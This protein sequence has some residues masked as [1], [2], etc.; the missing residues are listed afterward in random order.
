MAVEVEGGG[1]VEEFLGVLGRKLHVI[2]GPFFL[3]LTLGVCFSVIVP[4]KFVTE[5]RVMVR[6]TIADRS[7][8]SST[9]DEA[10]LASH[11]I[12]AR[13][14]VEKVLDELGWP[15]YENLSENLKL[16]FAARV[17][18]NIK[19]AVPPMPKGSTSQIVQIGYMD[20]DPDH[21]FAFLE[22]LTMVWRYEVLDQGR[23]AVNHSWRLLSDERAKLRNKRDELT[24]KMTERRQEF[25]IPVNGQSGGESSL[26]SPIFSQLDTVTSNIEEAKILRIDLEAKVS[27]HREQYDKM[28][29]TVRVI[30]VEEEAVDKV[31]DVERVRSK[32]FD[33]RRL[34]EEKGYKPANSK[35][36]AI[37]VQI[38][39]YEDEIRYLEGLDRGT[40]ERPVF[41]ENEER[42]KLAGQLEEFENE[43]E[44]TVGLIEALTSKR[45]ELMARSNELQEVYSELATW[46]AERDSLDEQ[47]AAAGLK[48]SE[49]L[50]EKEA[51]TDPFEVLSDIERPIEPTEPNPFMI[52]AVAAFLGA[53]L[54]LG[55]AVG[56]ELT[57]NCFRTPA[58]FSRTVFVP[59]LG[60]INGIHT[61][62]ELRRIR[63]RKQFMAACTMGVML[64][65]GSSLPLSMRRSRAFARASSRADGG[66]ACG[67]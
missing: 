67:T 17:Q 47:I 35:Y 31:T 23:N 39:N 1:Q 58:D 52:I 27:S 40:I 36:K 54:G 48:V 9:S 11:Q 29:P 55:L 25:G 4:K 37:M 56:T 32:I 42:A 8:I 61:S 10:K 66:E 65:F 59:V 50:I 30:E 44:T 38:A 26:A 12:K 33:L 19:V 46:Q 34:L 60:T 7:G 13:A 49:K 28:L 6:N 5:T 15:E 16:K 22:R 14:R 24:R 64:F 45:D 20:T 21:A 3:V 18:G 53:A 63:A 57:K 43:L 62:T 41:K 2:L 51:F